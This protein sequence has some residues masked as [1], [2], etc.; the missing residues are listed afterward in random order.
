MTQLRDT[1]QRD[2]Y[3][4]TP[5]I[6][7]EDV[8]FACEDDLWLVPATGGR[9]WRLTAGVAEAGEPRLS[10]DGELVAFVGRDEGP[11]D[12]YA[13]PLSGGSARRLTYA[14]GLTTL[15]GFDPTGGVVYATDAD[16]AFFRDRR[17]HRVSPD[18]GLP[19]V[20]PFGPAVA[21]DF[22][23][24]GAVVLARGY[25]DPAR[26]KRYRGG[27]TGDLWVDPDGSGEFR[28]LIRL[29]GNPAWPRWV[30]DRI[31]FLC[32]HEGVGNVYSCTPAGEDLRRHTD[33]EDFYARNLDS[34][35][36][37]LVYHAG[38]DLWLL[39]PDEDGPRRVPVRMPSA[40]TQR[41]RQFVAAAAHLESVTLSPDGARTAL[42]SRGKAFVLGHWTGPV[43]Q[44][45]EPDGVRYRLLT[46]LHDGERLVAAAS[47]TAERERLAVFG[48]DG[49]SRELPDLDTGRVVKLAASGV[50]DRV[51]LTN[52]RNELLLVDLREDPPRSRLLDHSSYG[53]IEDPVW[54]PDGRW[55]AYT[56]PGP[57]ATSAVKLADAGP[58]GGAWAVTRPVLRDR[59]PAFDPAGRYLYFIGQRHLDPVP[60][61]VAFDAGFPLASRP[62]AITLRADTPAPFVPVPAPPT[63]A[64]DRDPAAGTPEAPASEVLV[65]LAGIERRAVPFPV[66]DGRYERVA[67]TARRV[68]L[69][70]RPVRG[71]RQQDLF[72]EVPADWVLESYDLVEDRCEE[73]AT[74]VTDF[75]LS[76]DG[77]TLLYRA[78]DRVRVL[79]AGAKPP[80]A[81][82]HGDRPGRASG[83]VDLDRVKV[84]VRPEAEW[85]QMFREAWRLQR[86]GFWDPDMSGVDWDEVYQ[87]YAPL[88]ERVAT[89]SE[90]SDLLWELH[91]ELGTSHAYELGGAY[92]S[93]P[94]YRQ[95]FLGAEWEH[96]PDREGYRVARVLEGDP[97]SP[98]DTSPLNRPGVDVV[99]GDDLL[100]VNGV[101]VTASTTPDALLVN[102]ADQEVQLTVR[103]GDGPPRTVTVRALRSEQQVRY[104][105]W[106]EANRRWVHE[107][108]GGRVGYVHIPDMQAWGFA[109][110]HRGFLVEY[111][112]EALVV[113]VR[114]NRGGNVSP[115][116]LEKLARRRIAYGFGRREQPEP[117]PP[118][119][120]RGPL[121]ALT[122]ESAGSDGDIFSHAFK[123]MGLGSLVGKRTWGGV[124]GIAP[125]HR[126][127]DGT[128]TTQPEFAFAFDDVG[129]Q[130]ENY[131]TDPDIEVDNAP[132]DHAA[133][134]DPQLDRAADCALE[135][136]AARPAHAPAP[137]AL[138]AR[139]RPALPPRQRGPAASA[140]DGQAAFAP[141]DRA[142]SAPP[143]GAVAGDR[144]GDGD[145]G[146]RGN[147]T[148]GPGRSPEDG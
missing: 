56:C 142:A 103:R 86:D 41:N 126:L 52:H 141:H 105:D 134:R 15:S 65:D 125:R 34:D 11:A 107:R 112:R 43:R 87:R 30:G 104:R 92:R 81:G 120:P 45:G 27:R 18:G 121:V 78:G 35:G 127:A 63:S 12:V 38:A 3:L 25:A 49:S 114:H 133:G 29:D 128:V 124:V 7:G 42:T 79:A 32:D 6:R 4:R 9:A 116:L 57:A 72:G 20:L 46:H 39:D 13:M 60:D 89:R 109:E 94:D 83:W 110:F 96:R 131:G 82:T 80:E 85:R 2:G 47:D 40:R 90:L 69:L 8:V 61:E 97:W 145:H 147:P 1:Q 122:S 70:S 119:S 28:R 93:R 148:G 88:V 14:G 140:P 132:Q 26:W 5:A 68:L 54:S 23:P 113:D 10:A 99:A 111:D 16:Q 74:Q 95:G 143:V 67:G 101:P 98:D 17:L 91:G 24:G 66:P 130:V 44:Y 117:Y 123:L 22:V 100:A 106:V 129:W 58:G 146:D 48:A 21:V 75:V 118:E 50:D 108:S 37:R 115:R 136:L 71:T 135:A 137:P 55:V 53:P 36:T 62:Y 76:T 19:E 144:P 102:Q 64:T 73:V 51:A 33:H 139:T 59:R 31:Y 138:P 84:S 77:A